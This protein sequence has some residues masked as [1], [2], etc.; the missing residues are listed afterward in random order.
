MVQNGKL[1]A[2]ELN[3]ILILSYIPIFGW[4]GH[5]II[6]IKTYYYN[7]DDRSLTCIVI[8]TEKQK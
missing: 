4:V 3:I 5:I 6:I 2:V 1:Q 7:E 8:V